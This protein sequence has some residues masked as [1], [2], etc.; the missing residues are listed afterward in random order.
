M[1]NAPAPPH[2]R[3]TSID[4]IRGSI[5]VLMAIDHVRVYSGLPAGG[6]TAGI[7]FTRW[8][9]HFCAPGFVFLAGTSAFFYGR[10]HRDLSR[11]LLIRGAWLVFLELTVLRLAWTFNLDFAH[12]EMAG[13]IWCIGW[14]MIVL[15]LLVKLPLKA[16][17]AFGAVVVLGASLLDPAFGSVIQM[18]ATS[19]WSGLWKILYVSFYA[20]PI[21]LGADGPNLIVLYSIIPWVG[22]MA[23][24]YGFGTV[25][26]LE[27]ARRNRLCWQIGLG[28]TALFLVLRGFNLYGD[29]RHWHA[30][31]PTPGGPPQLPALFSFLNTNKYPASLD[32]L[33]MT[34]G[35][36]IAAIPLLE[37]AR[38]VLA[39]WLTVFGRVPFFFYVLHIPLIH[40]LALAVSSLRAG[41][42]DP[43][44]F[45]NHPMGN[46][47]PPDGYTWP[48]WLLYVV[49][50]TVIVILYFAS[51][52]FGALKAR[53]T[54]WWL[55]YL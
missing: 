29:P 25:L 12:Y 23:L 55:R 31:N 14:C 49:W 1:T 46:P 6:P 45:T 2:S 17:V 20:G 51:R 26:A 41:Q 5:M 39:R 40:A 3:I 11:H 54:E 4:V 33:L 16:V 47:P 21:Q 37:G 10:T 38:G 53:R 19:S 35:P 30:P 34:L 18:L 9:T 28:A 48:L 32:F 7:F 36:I 43:W 13:V 52:W 50:A 27:P 44:L 42:V 8:V 22:V 15:G 24:G